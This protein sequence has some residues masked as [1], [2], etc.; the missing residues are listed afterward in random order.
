MQ[1]LGQSP[2]EPT[3]QPT[4][5]SFFVPIAPPLSPRD[6]GG[7]GIITGNISSPT[8]D[9]AVRATSGTSDPTPEP[10]QMNKWFYLV[11]GIGI[12]DVDS[13]GTPYM[14]TVTGPAP[15]GAPNPNGGTAVTVEPFS[16]DNTGKALWKAVQSPNEGWFYLRSAQSFQTNT[17]ADF[18]YP[19]LLVGYGADQALLDLGYLPQW[20]P[21]A[22]I[23]WN[24]E[25]S[26]I[27]DQSHFQQWTY[28]TYWAQL[29]SSYGNQPL[30]NAAG[31]AMVGNGSPDS[32]NQWY[33]YPNYYVGQIVAQ[34]NSS[35]PFPA[36]P[37][38]GEQAA[39][40]YLSAQLLD[41]PET[42][43]IEGTSYSGMRCEY[44]NLDAQQVLSDCAECKTAFSNPGTYNGVSISASDWTNAT[45][46]L[47]TECNYASLVQT[48][49]NNNSNVLTQVFLNDATAITGLV[50]DLTLSETQ[51]VNMVA[52]DIIEG[53][54]YTMLCASGDPVAGTVANLM[55]MGVNT[56]LAAGGSSAQTLTEEFVTT[57]SNLYNQLSQAMTVVFDAMD[58]AETKILQDWGRLKAVGPLTLATGYNGLG[59]EPEKEETLREAAKKGYIISVMQ[60]LLPES[61]YGLSLNAAVQSDTFS[62]VPS[63]A[64]FS[65]STFGSDTSNFNTGYIYSENFAGAL[66][67]PD[68]TVMQ[69]NIL[70]N[71][72]NPFELFNGINGWAG[73]PL[74]TEG[75]QYPHAYSNLGCA[76]SVLTLF[77]ASSADLSIMVG[78]TQGMIA[79]PTYTYN[80]SPGSWGISHDPS[81]AEGNASFELR[82]YGY[83]PVWVTANGWDSENLTV[84]IDITD[85]QTGAWYSSFTFGGDGCNGK[86]PTYQWDVSYQS[87]WSGTFNSRGQ[88]GGYPA[89]LWMTL[90]Q[91]D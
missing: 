40:D 27:G 36:W 6:E 22:C 69:T 18:P 50:N 67:Y 43:T 5:K 55:E 24:Q 78:P 65:F 9:S 85:A 76:G 90:Y 20:S 48:T 45:E 44:I 38:E 33:T 17:N 49:F 87:G 28:D 23:F 61:V 79:A 19:N 14:L 56:A 32:G 8:V 10:V 39:Y 3:P 51:T 11:N 1:L 60:E 15:N 66:E 16:P 41:I 77:N 54:L 29:V 71:G 89:G 62:S 34:P 53:M 59:L 42:C 68:S 25:E 88:T 73:L 57:V 46:R 13:G 47:S 37:T 81:G 26:P 4:M 58:T 83:L 72:A 80:S 91:T 12:D 64:Q 2:P 84:N 21:S 30:Y 63:Y 75:S 82:P 7:G 74:G 31:N 35:P 52:L 86:V 70:D